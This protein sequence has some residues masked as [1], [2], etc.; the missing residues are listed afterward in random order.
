MVQEARDFKNLEHGSAR[1]HLNGKIARVRSCGENER[2]DHAA[3]DVL[4]LREIDREARG[5]RRCRSRQE[6]FKMRDILVV[7][8]AAHADGNVAIR[9]FYA[10][11]RPTARLLA[12]YHAAATAQNAQLFEP[13][14]ELRLPKYLKRS[15]HL[16]RALPPI[17]HLRIKVAHICGPARSVPRAGKHEI[18]DLFSGSDARA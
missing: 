13:I 17:Q 3:V 5:S 14:W 12:P 16:K 4:A 2:G 1:P 15:P 9:R 8:V 7:D 11:L 18:V 6:R 10:K